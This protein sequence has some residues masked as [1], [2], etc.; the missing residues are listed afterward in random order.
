MTLISILVS[1]AACTHSA[2]ICDAQLKTG[3]DP[4]LIYAICQVESKG[5]TTA[6]TP[7]DGTSPSYGMCQVKYRTA[8][9]LGFKGRQAE[10]MIPAINAEYAARYLRA[11]LW[12]Y[13]I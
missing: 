1:F 11:N 5:N 6:Y 9:W 2:P 12:R 13:K 3:I 7:A 4:N 8:E 10:L